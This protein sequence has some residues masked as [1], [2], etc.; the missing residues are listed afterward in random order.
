MCTDVIYTRGGGRAV[1]ET[2]YKKGWKGMGGGSG[3]K[4]MK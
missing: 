2:G 3:C 4:K 1:E